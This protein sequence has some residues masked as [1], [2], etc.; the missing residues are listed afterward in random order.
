MAKYRQRLGDEHG[1]TVAELTIAGFILVLLLVMVSSFFFVSTNVVTSSRSSALDAGTAANAM[2]ELSRVIRSSDN[3]PVINNSAAQPAVI[4]ATNESV[5]VY[6]F[7][8]SSLTNTSPVIVQFSLDATRNLV[9][10]RW[11]STSSTGGYFVFP[12]TL[13]TA[14]A[15]M[16]RTIGGPLSTTPTGKPPLFVYQSTA[17]SLTVPAGGFTAAQLGS[18]VSIQ[19]SVRVNTGATTGSQSVEMVNTVGLPNLGTGN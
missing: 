19:V 9:E 16:V 7:I 3:H 14:N 13:T 4:A 10:T 1:I 17:G 8:D 12:T 18:I 6:S 5:T 15:S 2:T 11:N